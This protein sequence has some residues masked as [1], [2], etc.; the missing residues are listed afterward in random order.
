MRQ[1]T[2]F[3]MRRSGNH[4]IIEWIASYFNRTEH[5]ND[6]YG[7][8]K[9][10]SKNFYGSGISCDLSISSYEDFA[11]SVEQIKDPNTYI[12]FRDWYNMMSSRLLSK[13]LFARYSYS[14]YYE[15]PN[16]LKVW[17]DFAKLYEENESKFILYNKWVVDKQ[18]RKLV[19]DRLNL[20]L[21]DNFTT[22]FPKSG[23]GS[24]SS[25]GDE[26]INPKNMNKRY[27]ILKIKNKKYFKSILKKEVS[28]YCKEIFDIDLKIK[29]L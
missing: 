12:V 4:P 15:N 11:P 19:Q 29:I 13:R 23:I 8:D 6:C 22:N 27:K 2:V 9:F 24:G 18:Y 3:G 16:V 10:F 28:S 21:S 14:K 5:Y 17:L 1:L 25:F 20:G 26:F 7:K